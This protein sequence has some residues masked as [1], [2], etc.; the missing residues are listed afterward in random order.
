MSIPSL[1]EIRERDERLHRRMILKF[2]HLSKGQLSARDREIVE[3]NQ[4]ALQRGVER[5][6]AEQEARN[7]KLRKV[8]YSGI[9]PLCVA[10]QYADGKPQVGIE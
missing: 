1:R 9:P 3:D 4:R 10:V 8:D 5:I 7:A 2:G 6:W